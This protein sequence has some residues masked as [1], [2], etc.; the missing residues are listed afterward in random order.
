MPLRRFRHYVIVM[1]FGLVRFGRALLRRVPHILL[2][3]LLVYI[4]MPI[5]LPLV[6]VHNARHRHAHTLHA[7]NVYTNLQNPAHIKIFN[8]VSDGVVCQCGCNFVLSSCP[9]VECPWGIPARRF[10]EAQIQGGMGAEEILSKMDKG[11]G[12][13]VREQAISQALI[14]AGRED[15]VNGM[16]AGWGPEIRAHASPI[17]L[18]AVIVLGLTLAVW[19]F[20]Y[21]RRRNYDA[22]HGGQTTDTPQSDDAWL[23][24][25]RDIDR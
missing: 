14:A 4:A 6:P 15:I 11:F 10:I 20:V 19:L 3:G 2:A 5:W 25:V 7:Q 23:D 24:R 12:A 8:E 21:W 17:P 18:I 22:S 13:G 16:I 1:R 9:H